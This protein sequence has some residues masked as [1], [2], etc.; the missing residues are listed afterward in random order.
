MLRR[1]EGRTENF[2]PRGQKLTPGGQLRP[3]GQSLP[4]GVKLRIEPLFSSNTIIKNP[5]SLKTYLNKLLCTDLKSDEH[6]NVNEIVCIEFG[7]Y[8]SKFCFKCR[9]VT[10]SS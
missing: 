2:T 4:L 7:N 3:W 8:F 6:K 5:H 9:K 1:M 10:Y